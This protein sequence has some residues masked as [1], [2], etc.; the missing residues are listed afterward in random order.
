MAKKYIAP[1]VDYWINVLRE[2]GLGCA[3]TD[4]QTKDL[5][6]ELFEV[7]DKFCPVGE[8]DCKEFW[9]SVP[10]GSFKE[11]KE[12]PYYCYDDEEE[13]Q[14]EYKWRYPEEKKWYRFQSVH[15]CGAGRTKDNEYF[16]VFVAS[17]YVLAVNDINSE[18]GF[19]I[20]A[21][22]FVLFLIE[23]AKQTIES[24]QQGTYQAK[25]E[26]ELP[27]KYRR[28]TILRKDYW[29]IVQEERKEFLE[30]LTESELAEFLSYAETFPKDREWEQVPPDCIVEMT[31]RDYYE[32]CAK[33]LDANFCKY[34]RC[35][36]FKDTEEEHLRYGGITP[37]EKYYS[38]ADGRDN[39]MQNGPMDDPKEL[40]LWLEGKGD[41]YDFNGS[42]PWEVLHSS[43]MFSIHHNRNN[44]SPKYYALSGGYYST[45]HETVR[46][47]LELK[48]AGLPVILYGGYRIAARYLETDRIGIV[49][50]EFS[51]YYGDVSC[52][53]G[54]YEVSDRYHLP[55][56][57]PEKTIIPRVEW[58]QEEIVQLKG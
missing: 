29:D 54:G 55:E 31:I 50:I 27:Y 39:G 41:F 58:I 45:C 13:E 7:T 57:V 25:I 22:E 33:G 37:K 17:E 42:H 1:F 19:P 2:S 46:F 10:C 3:N 24:V 6:K 21:T 14:E 52:Q 40:E 43:I 35:W 44:P 15:H 18:S 56:E 5:V 38:K 8:D 48:R 9:F 32:A 51:E 34:E 4:Q 53:M 28:G 26:Q 30:R 20:D 23:M 11:F 49:P 12:L 16:G 47:F 36:R